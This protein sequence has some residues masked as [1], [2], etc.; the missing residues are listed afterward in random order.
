MNYLMRQNDGGW[1]IA[2]I[3]L[4][5]TISQ[6]ATLRSQFSSVIARDGFAGLMTLLNSKAQ[7]LTASPA[8]AARP[9]FGSPPS[10]R[11][12]L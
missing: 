5:G 6:L 9:P 11:W 12:P 1:R 4:T 8:A 7:T 2:D 10:A 3:Y